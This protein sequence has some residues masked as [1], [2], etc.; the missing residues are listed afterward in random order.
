[1]H[2]TYYIQ[3]ADI[4]AFAG[5]LLIHTIFKI[6]ELVTNVNKPEDFT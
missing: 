2:T 6:Y 1:M 3:W 4:L 5:I